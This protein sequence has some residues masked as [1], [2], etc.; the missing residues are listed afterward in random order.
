MKRQWWMVGIVVGLI[1]I[2]IGGGWLVRDRFLPV[3]VGTRAP[4][5]AAT[6]L[7][8][9]PVRLADLAGEVVLL[10][11]WATWCA[12][13]REEMPSMQRLYDKMGPQG[14][15]VIAVSVDRPI[16][17]VDAGGNR[18][19]DIEAFTK[20]MGLTFDIWHDPAGGIQ[21]DYRTTGVP[22]SFVI[23]RQ[24]TI[25]KKVIGQTEWDSMSNIDLIERLL[26]G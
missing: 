25:V 8:G 26:E 9:N 3:E 7:D 19:G 12:P 10:N 23:D 16:G 1:A 24:G 2:L 18:G 15:H 13:C 21:R 20:Q 4:D 11:I 5:F 6:D 22:E 14:L 17:M